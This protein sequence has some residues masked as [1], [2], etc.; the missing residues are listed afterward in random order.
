[1]DPS[2]AHKLA[3]A[4]AKYRAHLTTAL[5][6]DPDPLA[7]YDSFVKWTLD[8]YG[9]RHLAQSGLLEL[10]EEATRYFLDD[11]AYK[12]DLRYTKLW[13]LYAK[14]V[15]DPTVIYEFMLSKKI[16]QIY[17]QVYEEYAYALEGRAR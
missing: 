16:G 5:A 4:R 3:H 15:E 9:P 8:C 10:L 11:D 12:S 2:V 13:L 17:A 1:M 6:E 7:A 14:Y